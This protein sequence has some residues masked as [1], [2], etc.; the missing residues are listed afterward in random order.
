MSHTV[1]LCTAIVSG[2]GAAGL[3]VIVFSFFFF[4]GVENFGGAPSRTTRKKRMSAINSTVVSAGCFAVPCPVHNNAWGGGGRLCMRVADVGASIGSGF[5]GVGAAMG[6]L[7]TV[8]DRCGSCKRCKKCTC[9]DR[10]WCLT[11]LW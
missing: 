8:W 1:S 7:C 10:E 11:M 4:G 2:G 9:R 3:V 5:P 6:M